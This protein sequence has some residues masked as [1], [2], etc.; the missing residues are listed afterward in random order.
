MTRPVS[1]L[2][3]LAIIAASVLFG[4]TGT[5][6]A[7]AP[8]SASALS[9]GMVRIALGGVLLGLI[10][11]WYARRRGAVSH[12]E[13]VEWGI[14]LV[15]AAGVF[16]Y[17]PA[18]FLGT[19]SNGVALGT[20]VALGSAP[21]MTGILTWIRT[22][23]IP[24]MPWWLATGFAIGGVVLLSGVL[25][26]AGAGM[27]SVPGLLGSLG[28]AFCY[29][30]YTV[31]AKSLMDR[32][33]GSLTA[34]GALFGVAGLAAIPVAASTPL[35]WLSEGRGISAALWLGVATIVL[36]YVFFGWGLKSLTA[37][38]VATVTLIEPVTATLL[39]IL[40][41]HEQLLTS[42][43]LGMALLG[44]GILVLTIA[45]GR[46]QPVHRDSIA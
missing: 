27:V 22:R 16:G 45:S 37:P 5:A 28:A 26:A 36:A 31:A 41:L 20:V 40:L 18:F 44:A 6:K 4:T 34:M 19:Q 2:P 33:W 43:I 17:Q 10:A 14:V 3:I 25:D 30:V 9:I 8:A 35:T 46:A 23:R 21:L 24:G 11:G 39:G 7:L 38:V 13:P 15:G 42:H 1:V 29:A 12:L 32:G